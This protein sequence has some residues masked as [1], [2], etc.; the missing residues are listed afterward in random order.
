MLPHKFYC[1]EDMAELLGKSVVS[2]RGHIAMKQY[3]AVPPPVRQGRKLVWL[4]EAVDKWIEMKLILA[5]AGVIEQK[6]GV[7]SIPL[8]QS[9]TEI[10]RKRKKADKT[11]NLKAVEWESRYSLPCIG[12]SSIAN[13]KWYFDGVESD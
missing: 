3:D 4:V 11:K 7:T 12:I 2:I 10:I 9:K 1:I 8:K 6:E 13:F 5:K